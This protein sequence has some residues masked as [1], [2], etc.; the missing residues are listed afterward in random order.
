MLPRMDPEVAKKALEQFPDFTKTAQ[1][2]TAS[3]K[4][5]LEQLVGSNADNMRDFNGACRSLLD[6]LETA[7]EREDCAEAE[8]TRI[9]DAMMQ[10]VRLMSEKDSENK[11]FLR[12]MGKSAAGACLAV[13]LALAAVLG[14]GNC[15]TRR[16]DK[17]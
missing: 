9:I 8:R 17:A 5:G 2:I 7:L 13:I 1:T 11:A 6:R 16:A 10:I 12:E 15:F 4:E 3:L 14:V